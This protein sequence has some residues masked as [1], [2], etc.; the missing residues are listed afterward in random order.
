MFMTW[1][2]RSKLNFRSSRPF[3]QF[4]GV[5]SFLATPLLRE[6]VAIGS[7]VIRRTEVR[8]FSD[9]Q[10]ALLKTFA[11]QAVIAIENVRLFQELRPAIATLPKRWSS[12]RQ[13][14][15]SF[16][17]IASSPTD[18]QPVLDAVVENAARLC[19]ANDAQ[20]SRVQGDL[21]GTVA[22]FGPL[23]PTSEKRSLTRTVP[24]R[25]SHHRSGNHPHPGSG[26]SA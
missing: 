1:L 4:R 25:P 12:R 9:K 23:P 20:I 24:S 14:A 10:I 16:G 6:G 22:S 15:R 3:S 13:R 11:D 2:Q 26:G 21:Y 17:I 5:R 7:I 18:V 19:E 8:P